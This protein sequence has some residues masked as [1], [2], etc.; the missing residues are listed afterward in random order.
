MLY[1]RSLLAVC[2]QASRWLCGKR[3]RLLMQKMRVGS[4]D[5][6][7]PLRKE[8]AARLCILAWKTPWTERGAWQATVHGIEK[9]Q[10]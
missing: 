4:L 7:D 8:M 2:V 6:E 9:S 10:T 3:I 1:S 5:Q